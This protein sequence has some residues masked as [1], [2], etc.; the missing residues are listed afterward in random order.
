MQEVTLHVFHCHCRKA[1]WCSPGALVS[2]FANQRANGLVHVLDHV[3][4]IVEVLQ[5]ARRRGS[6]PV[7]LVL[8]RMASVVKPSGSKRRLADPGW[9]QGNPQSGRPKHLHKLA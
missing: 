6:T 2:Q 8:V 9:N 3:D 4:D 5:F 1:Q 7:C